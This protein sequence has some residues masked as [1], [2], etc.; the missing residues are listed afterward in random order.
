MSHYKS[1]IVKEL[2]VEGSATHKVI[3]PEKEVEYKELK[4]R[5]NTPPAKVEK[6]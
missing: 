3:I 6:E 5:E 4:E 1:T 2:N